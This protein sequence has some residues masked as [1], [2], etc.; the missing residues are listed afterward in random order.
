[1]RKF[2]ACLRE[3]RKERRGRSEVIAIDVA[4]EFCGEDYLEASSMRSS[5]YTCSGIRAGEDYTSTRTQESIDGTCARYD[6][7]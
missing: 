2:A 7:V 6:Y 5:T 4:T 3:H 1:M